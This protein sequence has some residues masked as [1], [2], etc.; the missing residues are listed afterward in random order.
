MPHCGSSYATQQ[1]AGCG[2]D[3]E[4]VVPASC[5]YRRSGD[6]DHRG[7][8]RGSGHGS[9]QGSDHHGSKRGSRD[10]RRRHRSHHS[11][12]SHGGPARGYGGDD[13]SSSSSSGS[14][15]SSSNGCCREERRR[16]CCG[17]CRGIGPR[18]RGG[19][20]RQ[21]KRKNK[22][23]VGLRPYGWAQQYPFCT[24]VYYTNNNN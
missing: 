4:E 6:D 7:S 23:N 1:A 14:Y 19:T 20:G 2:C 15:S 13:S 16:K 18:N 3:V 24:R 5:R 8:K 10:R 21:A 17:A 12:H 9:K 22:K 11:H